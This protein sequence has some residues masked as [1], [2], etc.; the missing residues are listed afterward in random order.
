MRR[1]C[2]AGLLVVSLLIIFTGCER[3]DVSEYTEFDPNEEYMVTIGVYGDL[4]AAYTEV[5]ASDDFRSLYPNITIQFQSSDFNGHHNRLTTTIAANEISN[6]IEALEVAFIARFVEGDALRDLADIPFN[7]REIADNIVSFAISNATTTE[8]KLVAMPVDVAPM[9]L[10]YREDVVRDSGV[11]PDTI[12]QLGSWEE[13]I[14]VGRQLTRDTDG[15]GKIDQYAIPHA[16][17]V[18]LAPL[19]GGKAGW[20]N[21]SGNPFQPKERFVRSLQLVKDVRDAGIDADFGA[22]S[23]PWVESFRNGAVATIAIG[24][25]FGGALRT[26]IAPEVSDWRVALLPGGA[27]ASFGGTYLAIPKTVSNDRLAAAWKVLEYL[28]SSASSQLT[29]FRTIDAFPALEALYD[30]PVMDEPVEYFGGQPV[31]QLFAE[32]AR[33]I[34]D[35]TVHEYDALAGS[36]WSNSV[37]EVLLGGLDVEAAYDQAVAQVQASVQ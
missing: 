25:W 22:W 4:E 35:N 13:F 20:F 28:T 23:G 1:M 15:D 17:D 16:N 14:E 37:T 18:A 3:G 34:P 6:D 8:G 21:S 26:W 33:S 10:F 2:M 9:M 12:R 36:I 27:L 5:F 19:N 30:D 31:R 32:I 11:D 29:A 7:G 24:A